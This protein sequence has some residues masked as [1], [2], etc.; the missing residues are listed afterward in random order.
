[1]IAM[2]LS[3]SPELIIADEPTTALDVTIQAQIVELIK[4]LQA[5]LGTAVIWITHDLGVVARLADNVAVMYAGLHRREGARSTIFTPARPSLHLRAPE[6]AAAARCQGEGEAEGDRRPS[7]QSCRRH[8]TAA[9]SCRAAPMRPSGAGAENP[10]LA[11]VEPGHAVACW[12]HLLQMTEALRERP[13]ARSA[14]GELKLYFPIRGGVAFSRTAGYFKAVDGIS[15]D[16]YRGETLGLV[17]ESGCGKTTA[18][19]AILQLYRPTGGEVIFRGEDL[20]RQSPDEIRR[21]RRHMQMIFQDPY[22]SLNPQMRVGEII[23]RPLRVHRT[24]VQP[25]RGS[26]AGEPS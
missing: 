12:N 1:M 8:C 16:I 2:A 20:V 18:G 6:L 21:A 17:G 7:A 26:R 22:A 19:R 25:R 4:R 10:P 14:S 5:E 11:E 24:V 3:C 23:A 15:F 9:R 13:G